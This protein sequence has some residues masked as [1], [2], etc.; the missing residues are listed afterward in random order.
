MNAEASAAYNTALWLPPGS[1]PLSRGSTMTR[2]VSV[3]ASLWQLPIF[4][5]RTATALTAHLQ[6][7]FICKQCLTYLS[8]TYVFFSTDSTPGFSCAQTKLS[9]PQLQFSLFPS[10]PSTLCTPRT[11]GKV[12][13][14]TLSISSILIAMTNKTRTI[15]ILLAPWG[16]PL[17]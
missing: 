13:H 9:A 15:Q 3:L 7:S 1:L 12:R 10:H 4:Q 11:A 16:L 17:L 14:I 6:R 8:G 2:G 5:A